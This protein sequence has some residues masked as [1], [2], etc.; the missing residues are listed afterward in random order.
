MRKHIAGYPG[1]INLLDGNVIVLLDHTFVDRFARKH[2]RAF[3]GL[4]DDFVAML[5]GGLRDLVIL[6]G[7]IDGGL[8]T[9]RDQGIERVPMNKFMQ[10]PFLH[11]LS[12][13]Y[14]RAR[15]SE[16]LRFVI[17]CIIDAN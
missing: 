5:V 16:T 6:A 10:R 7:V 8:F 12:Q 4:L 11:R 15:L 13:H 9:R 3:R 2:V 14:L 1:E 17:S